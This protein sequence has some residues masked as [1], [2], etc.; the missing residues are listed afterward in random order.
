MLST[1]KA[2]K[3]RL[4]ARGRIY[5]LRVN[6]GPMWHIPSR[7]N[8]EVIGLWTRIVWEGSPMVPVRSQGNTLMAR[9]VDLR[10]PR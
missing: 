5:A 6:L 1:R 8:I 7:R 4:I 10:P 9:V 2:R 3:A